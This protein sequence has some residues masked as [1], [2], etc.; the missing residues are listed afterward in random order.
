MSKFSGFLNEDSLK[1]MGLEK[2]PDGK[3][4][5]PV[6]K[7]KENAPKGMMPNGFRPNRPILK[8]ALNQVTE[9]PKALIPKKFK[10]RNI[11]TVVDGYTFA[12]V[13][14]ATYYGKLKMGLFAKEISSV[15][16]QPVFRLVVNEQLICKYVADFEVKYMD[17]RHEIIDV[18]SDITRKNRAYRIK[19]KLLKALYNIDIV[20]V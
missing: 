8:Q 12:S 3:W 13:K 2:Q 5:R 9:L 4:K 17:G 7:V 18:K 20:E 19:V 1:I 15:I 11:K 16:L 10:Y 14:E 6:P